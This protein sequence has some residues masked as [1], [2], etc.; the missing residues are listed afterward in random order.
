MRRRKFLKLAAGFASG[1]GAT[2]P[3]GLAFAASTAA[4]PLLAAARRSKIILGMYSGFHDLSFDPEAQR[5]LATEFSMI[6]VG[7][8]LKFSDRLRPA[9]DTYDFTF[10]DYDVAWAERHGLLFRGHTFVWHNALPGWFRSYVDKNNAERVMTDH[11]ATVAKHYK[12]RIYSWDVV[13]EPIHDEG[14]PDQ[15]RRRPWLDLLGPGYI[16]TA[17]QAAAAADPKARR[18]LNECYIE[19]DSP[20]EN[21]RRQAFL[22]L[23]ARLKKEN[24]PV[25]G[26]GIQGHLRGTVPLATDS[27][28][29]FLQTVRDMG[30]EIMVTEL[31]VDDTGIPGPQVDQVVARKY[32]E[33][34]DLV[35]PYIS[36]VTFEQLADDKNLPKRADGLEHRPN[37]FDDNY[38]QKPAYSA[39]V[40]ALKAARPS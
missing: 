1:I 7:N 25:T 40:A 26:I 9:P 29:H 20:L 8:D 30:L 15:L 35:G 5:L 12:G 3:P 23:I 38:Q 13:N 28:K 34:L 37:L 14:R 22:D 32:G 11:I 16:E 24:T 17:F 2:V 19:H 39:S 21:P 27:M 31:D 10:G 36:A 4:P 6:A 33:F 18:I